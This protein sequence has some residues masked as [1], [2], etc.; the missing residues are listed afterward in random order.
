MP[1]INPQLKISASCKRDLS[2]NRNEAYDEEKSDVIN[3]RD[4]KIA[5]NNI[6]SINKDSTLIRNM[7]YDDYLRRKVSELHSHISSS[8]VQR[9]ASDTSLLWAVREDD[10]IIKEDSERVSNNELDLFSDNTSDQVVDPS[11]VPGNL[12]NARARSAYQ[13][14]KEY[15]SQGCVES[16]HENSGKKVGS[17]ENS[18]GGVTHFLQ[19]SQI[20]AKKKPTI[21]TPSEQQIDK[22]K[23]RI[24]S[25]VMDNTSKPSNIYSKSLYS[26]KLGLL[27]PAIEDCVPLF[28]G[29][30]I[31][32]KVKSD[33]SI[34]IAPYPLKP[35]KDH[36]SPYQPNSSAARIKN[37]KRAAHSF[38]RVVRRKALQGDEQ[39]TLKKV[40]LTKIQSDDQDRASNDQSSSK[41]DQQSS[42]ENSSVLAES[43]PAEAKHRRPKPEAKTSQRERTNSEES[44]Q[45]KI[46]S[47]VMRYEMKRQQRR[48]IYALNKVMTDLENERFILFMQ[49]VN[50]NTPVI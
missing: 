35:S 44:K 1:T 40:Y 33:L 11:V 45:S 22:Q 24:N 21:S 14:M 10:E 27:C 17:Q 23:E 41:P 16:T 18:G 36:L 34:N 29:F 48:E 32:G 15:L 49:E 12:R 25:T 13:I 8:H 31:Q 47:K 28:K 43:K 5:G 50:S 37:Y 26:R 3:E 20:K 2:A 9:N 39:T 7:Q 6:S 46:Q 30:R 19:V 4:D 42:C 38:E